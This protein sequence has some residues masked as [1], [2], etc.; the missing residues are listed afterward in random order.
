[1]VDSPTDPDGDGIANNG[2]LDT[3]PTAFGGLP[4]PDKD[5]DGVA[6][7]SDQDDDNDGILDT[8]E[9]GVW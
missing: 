6:D 1:M 9:D 8:A 3:Q 2:G 5:G 7:A 4:A